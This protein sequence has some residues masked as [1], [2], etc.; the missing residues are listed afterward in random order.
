M[1]AAKYI[2]KI[3]LWLSLLF[4]TVR[5]GQIWIADVCLIP[6]GSMENEIYAGDRI[7]VSKIGRKNIRRN[8]LIVFNHPDGGGTQLIKRCIG[9]PGETVILHNGMVYINDC[10]I[11]APPTVIVPKTDYTLDFPLKSLEWTINNYGPVATPQK[12]LSIYLDS[13]NTSLYQHVIRIERAEDNQYSRISE[14]DYVF[15]TDSYFVLGDNRSNSID[16]RYWGFV[17]KDLIVGKAVMIY[18]SK[19]KE[20]EKIRWNRIGKRFKH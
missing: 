4:L 20:L 13:V 7:V 18:F 8:D 1:K 3:L 6:T 5:T 16:S 9:L 11:I 17:P 19:D 14:E 12:G 2:A 10:A 15:K